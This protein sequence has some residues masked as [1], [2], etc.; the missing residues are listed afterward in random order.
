MKKPQ[1]SNSANKRDLSISDTNST[2]E[3]TLSSTKVM[4]GQL[5]KKISLLSYEESLKALDELLDLL[6]NDTVPV[7]DLQRSYLLG[8]LYLE[9]CEK[10]L[11]ITEQEI[12]E[13]NKEELQDI[14][15]E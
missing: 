11:N 4:L 1:P 12:V 15:Q 3:H 14:D 6:Q 7:E 13:L 9:H 2:L 5:D 8:N 10:L